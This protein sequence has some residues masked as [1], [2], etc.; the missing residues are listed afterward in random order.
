MEFKSRNGRRIIFD[1]DEVVKIYKHT[2]ENAK[3]LINK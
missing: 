2:K 3:V 1:D